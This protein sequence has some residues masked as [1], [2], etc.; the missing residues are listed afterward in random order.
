MILERRKIMKI[1]K[2]QIR[3][4]LSLLVDYATL[5]YNHKLK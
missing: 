1:I 5:K 3:H 2:T 4:S